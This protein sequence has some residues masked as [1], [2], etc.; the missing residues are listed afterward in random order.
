MI[1][2]SQTMVLY[3]KL[4]YLSKFVDLSATNYNL[5]DN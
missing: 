2:A 5:V 4:I 1:K 3:F